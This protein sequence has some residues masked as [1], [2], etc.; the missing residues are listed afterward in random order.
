MKKA[1]RIIILLLAVVLLVSCAKGE[2]G[3][4]GEADDPNASGSSNSGTEPQKD[5]TAMTATVTAISDK[6]EV[7]VIEGDYGA[8]GPYLVIVSDSTTI[9]GKNG[10]SITRDDI[11]VGDTVE[12]RYGGQ[13]M[14]SYPPQ[15]VAAKITVVE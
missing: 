12:I 6:I 11:R 3:A 8:T 13:V 4:S 9:L 2:D 10:E 15:I 7:E 5:M 14:M 1:W